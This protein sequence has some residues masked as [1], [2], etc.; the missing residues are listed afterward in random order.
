M[1]SLVPATSR[2]NVLKYANLVSLLRTNEFL[3]RY[4]NLYW[5]GQPLALA[6]V[7]AATA[8]V[9]C[10]VFCALFCLV[11]MRGDFY[12]R[13][14]KVLQVNGADQLAVLIH[15][16]RGADFVPVRRLPGV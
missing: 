3:G 10:T 2:W 8:V 6:V 14:V 4:H 1:R 9:C 12:P 5:F 7:T 15:Y 11:F 16:R 13:L